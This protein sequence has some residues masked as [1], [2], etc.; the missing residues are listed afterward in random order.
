MSVRAIARN[1]TRPGL[2]A[3]R[4][5]SAP[6][7]VDSDDNQLKIIPGG[8]GSTTEKFVVT[9]DITQNVG[10][11]I[12]PTAATE[13]TAAQSGSVVFLNAATGFA[14]TLPAP[15]AGLSFKF[16]V[17]A[18]FAT[19]NF[20][21]VTN[22]SSNIIQGGADVNSTWVPAADEDTI[23][24]VATAETKGDWIEVVSNGTDWFASGQA[25]A[26]GA[27]TFTVAS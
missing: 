12:T 20:T 27:I 11:V 18:A 8:Q 23:S 1:A 24:F 14:I 16:V 2:Y 13:L 10:T 19:T 21:I 17:A 6:I 9:S 3:G 22:G 15:A 7:Y 26:A 5:K 4:T 25:T